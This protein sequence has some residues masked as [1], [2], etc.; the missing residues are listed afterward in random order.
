[1]NNIYA[2][3]P[4]GIYPEFISVNVEDD[5]VSFTVRSP[6]KRF[7]LGLDIGEIAAIRLSRDEARQMAENILKA[8]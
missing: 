3:T 4:A 5:L 8:L 2:F 7:A 1:M 6:P